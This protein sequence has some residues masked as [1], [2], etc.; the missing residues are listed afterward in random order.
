MTSTERYDKLKRAMARDK[1]QCCMC[2][3]SIFGSIVRCMSQ[4]VFFYCLAT[5]FFVMG[6]IVF[7]YS[8]N[9]S[10]HY[11]RIY[12]AN[13]ST[14]PANEI[15]RKN[16]PLT[17]RHSF[18]GII[19]SIAYLFLLIPPLTATS[20]AP[21]QSL[22]YS[23]APQQPTCCERNTIRYVCLIVTVLF[24]LALGGLPLFLSYSIPTDFD[25][26]S[27]VLMYA[28]L[29]VFLHCIMLSVGVGVGVVGTNI[30]YSDSRP[31]ADTSFLL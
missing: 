3:N 19:I 2:I 1:A 21:E 14:S 22:F 23:Q 15:L 12:L 31:R 18:P 20:A 30:A 9:W 28:P 27:D 16:F 26:S 4:P 5:A 7:Y 8:V 25:T 11:H 24:G 29:M 6:W 13:N 17:S 10:R